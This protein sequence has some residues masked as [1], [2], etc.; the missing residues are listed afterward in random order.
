[1]TGTE[2]RERAMAAFDVAALKEKPT[3]SH[4]GLFSADDGP[5]HSD[6]DEATFIWFTDR[7]AMLSFVEEH[8]PF[9]DLGAVPLDERVESVS[10]VREIIRCVRDGNL[11]V[12]AARNE[13]NRALRNITKVQWWGSMDDLLLSPTEFAVDVRDYCRD[14]KGGSTPATPLEFDTFVGNIPHF[15]Y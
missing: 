13:V 2:M 15:P 6:R 3:R 7:D 5:I 11:D 8:L 14:R 12:E 9:I 4:W 1:M 10:T